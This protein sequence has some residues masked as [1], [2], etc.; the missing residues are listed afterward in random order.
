MRSLHTSHA[1]NFQDMQ[2]MK[3]SKAYNQSNWLSTSL[4]TFSTPFYTIPDPATQFINK[5]WYFD[6]LVNNNN[7]ELY[8]NDHTNTYSIA[9]AM[10]RNGNYNSDL[11]EFKMAVILQWYYCSCLLQFWSEIIR[12]GIG[13][14][15]SWKIFG[16]RNPGLWNPNTAHISFRN[17]K[18]P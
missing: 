1:C 10:F 14:L 7:N 18:S 13:I 11:W 2:K 8:L 4:K 12:W 16:I 17:P 15:K 3:V 6:L 5:S 9:K